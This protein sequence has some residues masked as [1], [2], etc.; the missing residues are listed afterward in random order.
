MHFGCR[1][2]RQGTRLHAS[3]RARP[4]DGAVSH[5]A[6]RRSR[7]EYREV[8]RLRTLAAL[9]R[10][11]VETDFLS[12][13]QAGQAG[14]LDGRNMHEHVFLAAFRRDE[15]EALCVVEELDCAGLRHGKLL[16]PIVMRARR[17]LFHAGS[18]SAGRANR[19]SRIGTLPSTWRG[20]P[21]TPVLPA[22]SPIVS[23]PAN[24]RSQ[25]FLYF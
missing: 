21:G 23:G 4:P 17:T 13:F 3:C 14:C 24:A 18:A 5:N 6:K 16:Y 19:F 22:Q 1:K 20:T 25:I 15:A 10:L 7:S 2:T 11:G 12:I 9:I 8:D